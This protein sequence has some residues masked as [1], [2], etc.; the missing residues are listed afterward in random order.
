MKEGKHRSS[1]KMQ[2][3]N[4]GRQTKWISRIDRV[5]VVGQTIGIPTQYWYIQSFYNWC[6]I[7]KHHKYL[8]AWIRYLYRFTNNI[9]FRNVTIPWVL[10]VVVVILRG[11]YYL[12]RS[13]FPTHPCKLPKEWW[14]SK[15]LH[16][17]IGETETVP[18]NSVIVIHCS[19]DKWVE[20]M[21][22]N[23]NIILIKWNPFASNQFFDFNLKTDLFINSV[24]WWR[25]CFTNT[26]M[27]HISWSQDTWILCSPEDNR[28]CKFLLGIVASQKCIGKH[29]QTS[30][31]N[32][33]SIITGLETSNQD[34][35]ITNS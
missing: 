3:S 20:S 14:K 26:V 18:E 6:G 34:E 17:R 16:L 24:V 35:L 21:I 25:V 13:V 2:R 27:S 33:S 11:K 5:E 30:R 7:G 8:E 32:N 10:I 4:K 15:K 1:L 31:H 28:F 9:H 19:S 12:F 23:L 29:R 22:V